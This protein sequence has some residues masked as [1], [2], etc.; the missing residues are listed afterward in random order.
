[1]LEID[2]AGWGDMV[3]GVVLGY[4]RVETGTFFSKL[5]DVKFFKQPYF[6]EK[7]YLDE[8]VR[9]T[10][11]ALQ[12]LKVEKSE[13][14]R[15]CTAAV[16]EKVRE[17]LSKEGYKVVPAKIVGELQFRVEGAFIDRLEGLGVPKGSVP[18]EP[19]KE[20]FYAQLRWI[21]GDLANREKY[22]KTAY[23]SWR[24]WRAWRPR[25]RPRIM[26]RSQAESEQ[27]WWRW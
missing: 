20:R 9:L 18:F 7:K 2:D 23:K 15:I 22:V 3:E 6:K 4:L 24:R 8:A 12:E 16:L 1:M 11:D 17:T 27:D 5:I 10:R 14:I 25:Q 13:E 21:H 19:G 26:S